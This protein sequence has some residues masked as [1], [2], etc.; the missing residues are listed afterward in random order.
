MAT[1]AGDGV[2]DPADEAEWEPSAQDE[3]VYAVGE[4]K[5][6]ALDETMLNTNPRW[7]FH[8]HVKPMHQ[9]HMRELIRVGRH[10]KA[11]KGGRQMSF[12]AL[13]LAGNG[14]GT[15][16]LGY[17]KALKVADAVRA[18]NIDAEKNLVHLKRYQGSR[19]V[20]SLRMRHKGCIIIKRAL[21]K[22]AGVKGNYLAR[23]MCEA[24]GIEGMSL[25]IIGPRS[26]NLGT[27]AKAL[28]KALTMQRDP[29]AEAQAMG[30]MLFSTTKVWRRRD[31]ESIY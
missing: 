29:E 28:F 18:A 27:R 11:L 3:E 20:S 21:A 12:S 17:G 1:E 23:A 15:A 16:G 8:P 7:E 25:K 6:S 4:D 14:R 30:K 26:K 5:E 13:I 19:N 31:M 24:F 2:T 10:M 22:G 9:L